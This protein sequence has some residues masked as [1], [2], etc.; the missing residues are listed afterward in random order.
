MK[1]WP[2]VKDP[3]SVFEEL[4][5]PHLNQLYRL[6]YRYTGTKDDAEDLVQDL[7]LKL[8]PRLQ[9]MQG[10]D[11]LAPWLVRILYHQ[12]VD[13][14]RYQ[15]RSPIDVPGDDKLLYDTH[16][17]ETSD[18]SVVAN[19]EITRKLLDTALMSLNEDQRLLVVLHDVEGYSLLEINGITDIPVG[20]IKSRLSR[21]R[22]KLREVLRKMEPNSGYNVLS[23]YRG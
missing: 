11:K 10:I 18:P 14:F 4:I 2:F 12:F 1:I 22:S 20:T 8:Y 9:E 5:G 13:Q 15:K 21:A 3:H 6:A 7:L 16:A 23:R 19:S 17:S